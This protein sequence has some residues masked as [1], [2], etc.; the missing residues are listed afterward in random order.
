MSKNQVKTTKQF[1]KDANI[2]HNY[3]Y[4]YSL[5]I[6]K[7]NHTK[8]RIICPI[9]GEFEQTPII[10]LRPCGCSKCG[11]ATSIKKQTL[12]QDDFIKRSIIKHSDENG[13]PKFNYS[14]IKYKN[15]NTKIKLICNNCKNIFEQ[16]PIN[17]LK[18]GCKI[19][20]NILNGLNCRL[21]EFDFIARSQNLHL[22]DFG[23]PKYIYTNVKYVNS[24]TPIELIC[25]THGLFKQTPNSHLN[26][27]GCPKCGK[28]NLSENKLVNFIKNNYDIETEYKPNWLKSNKY[29]GQSLDIYFSNYN[30]A[31][32]YQGVQ[33]FKPINFFGGIKKFKYQLE[34]D[35]RKR[36]LCK[37]NNVI[38]LYFTYQKKTIPKN[39]LYK[40]F[41]DENELL[42]E[43]KKII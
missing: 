8:I 19:C 35:E 36:E 15:N 28:Q 12:S 29:K 30:I 22:N 37:E 18:Y 2:I 42:S 3:F 32:E 21:D 41:T 24:A 31:I 9:H 34:L 16:L 33:H 25:P 4:N 43:I 38:L 6:Y 10:H 26:G 17:H 1:I 40:V 20:A 14:L 13:N 27:G 39:Y 5:V 23:S 7:N 11:L